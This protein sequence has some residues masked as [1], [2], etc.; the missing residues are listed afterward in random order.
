[1][2][3]RNKSAG[4]DKKETQGQLTSGGSDIRIATTLPSSPVIALFFFYNRYHEAQ[5]L[6]D[7]APRKQSSY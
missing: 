6:H 7:V 3:P 1:M 2:D 4:D 5:H